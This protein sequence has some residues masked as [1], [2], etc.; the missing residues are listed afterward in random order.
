MAESLWDPEGAAP[1][2]AHLA[3]ALGDWTFAREI[4]EGVE[5]AG[6]ELVRIELRRRREFADALRETLRGTLTEPGTGVLEALADLGRDVAE[7]DLLEILGRGPGPG[8]R[9]ALAI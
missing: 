1:T 7:S 8:A 6:P 9:T 3:A 2:A 5:A 4:V